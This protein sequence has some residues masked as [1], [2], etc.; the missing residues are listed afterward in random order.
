MSYKIE[1]PYTERQKVDFIVQYNH[2]RGLL[3]EETD[4]QLIALEPNEIMVNGVPQINPE[5]ETKQAEKQ[6][7]IR[8]D[9][10]KLQL[11]ELDKKRIRAICEPSMKTENQ[12]WLEYYNEQIRQIRQVMAEL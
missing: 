10:L 1:K 11:E 7:Q 9:E 2:N 12:S 4:T 6:K 3:I 8:I 5:Y